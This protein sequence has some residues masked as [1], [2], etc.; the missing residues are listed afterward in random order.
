M[1]SRLSFYVSQPLNIPLL[2]SD[3]LN[4]ILTDTKSLGILLAFFDLPVLLEGR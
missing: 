1:T 4:S 2:E 3:Y